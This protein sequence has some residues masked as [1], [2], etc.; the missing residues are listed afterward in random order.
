M[1]YIGLAYHTHTSIEFW[2]RMPI[3]E[4]EEWG[5]VLEELLTKKPEIKTDA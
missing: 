3:E 4:A 5:R 2:M 1:L